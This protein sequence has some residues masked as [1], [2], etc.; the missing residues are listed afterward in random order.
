MKAKKIVIEIVK[1][2]VFCALVAVATVFISNLLKPE[3]NESK[4]TASGFRT[5]EKDSLDVVF[6]GSSTLYRF[7][8]PSVLWEQEGFTSYVYAGPAMPFECVEPVIKEV[9]KTQKPDLVV[10]DARRIARLAINELEGS[11][12]EIYSE[13]N[14]NWFS[15]VVNNF[16]TG[17]NKFDTILKSKYIPA[18]EKLLYITEIGK[19]HS[20]WA[21]VVLLAREGN[22]DV[23]YDLYQTAYPQQ[24][25]M[26]TARLFNGDEDYRDYADYIAS[27][28]EFPEDTKRL[29]DSLISYAKDNNIELLFVDT[30]FIGVNEKMLNMSSALQAI[31]EENGFKYYEMNYAASSLGLDEKKHYYDE[32][33]TNAWGAE[34][35]T[36]ALGE[37][38]SKNYDISKNHTDEVTKVY[39]ASL[40]DYKEMYEKATAILTKFESAYT[41]SDEEVR[42]AKLKELKTEGLDFER[43]TN[44]YSYNS[45]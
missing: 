35:V 23:G 2:L 33:H 14:R 4:L 31:V 36:R 9:E 24:G 11:V 8:A 17:I 44:P 3:D 42:S 19:Y 38:I 6:V 7:V 28:M 26:M 43:D 39:D 10:V 18:D 41:I 29:L 15:L 13:A 25:Y 34:I 37:Y 12:D 27:P 22:V 1:A 30:P 45:N 40:K 16:P 32:N 21:D 5:H 20:R